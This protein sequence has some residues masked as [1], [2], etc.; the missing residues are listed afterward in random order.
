MDVWEAK[1]K[2]EKAIR[3]AGYTGPMVFSSV[4]KDELVSKGYKWVVKFTHIKSSFFSPVTL[5]YT[6]RVD[7]DEDG[8]IIYI[9]V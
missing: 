4:E 7:F 2:A 5:I 9:D 8:N 1:D 3:Q 6:Y